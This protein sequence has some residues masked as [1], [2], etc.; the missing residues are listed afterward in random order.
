MW[1]NIKNNQ[2]SW[3]KAIAE[4]KTSVLNQQFEMEITTVQL[5]LVLLTLRTFQ[6]FEFELT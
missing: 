3:N 4:I 5:E 2:G 6:P 1:S